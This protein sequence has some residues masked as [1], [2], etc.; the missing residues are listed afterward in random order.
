MKQ[1][2][3]STASEVKELTQAI[4]QLAQAKQAENEAGKLVKAAKDV[5]RR[6]LNDTRKID[7]DTLPEGETV[8][9][10][11]GTERGLK[12]D[13]KGSDRIDIQSLR[14]AL[15]DVAKQYTK[16]TVASYFETL[17]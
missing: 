16:R 3:Y 14:T 5:I 8:I 4:D 13:R 15:P 11:V 7:V 9:V 10:T 17:A 6:V 12:I 1:V 2:K